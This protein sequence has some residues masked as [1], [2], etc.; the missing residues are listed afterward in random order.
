MRGEFN[1]VQFFPGG[2]YEYVRMDVGPEEAARAAIQYSTSV[3][4]KVGTTERVIITDSG[5]SICWE[6][7]RAEGLTFPPG[8]NVGRMK[9]GARD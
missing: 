8:P 3:G 7:K 9:L 4:A 5:D 6:W 2:A 1:V